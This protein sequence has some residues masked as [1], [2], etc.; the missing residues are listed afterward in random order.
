MNT[1]TL[2]TLLPAY[3]DPGTGSYVLQ[4]L[5]AA[6][7]GAGFAVKMYW[8]NIRKGLNKLFKKDGA[9]PTDES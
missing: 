9:N 2:L 1:T 4:L 8:K 7:L 3:L 5:I 6:L